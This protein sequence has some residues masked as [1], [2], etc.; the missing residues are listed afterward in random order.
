[1]Q[2]IAII[3]GGFNGIGLASA[4]A[5]AKNGAKIA[6]GARRGDDPE[7]IAYAKTKIGADIFTAKLDVADKASVED[8]VARVARDLGPANILVNSAGIST[9]Q[10]VEGHSEDAWLNVINI[11]LNGVFRMIRACL[12]AMKSQGFGRIVN[13]AS[14]A[15]HT[16]MSEYAA[17]CASK[18]GLLGLTR[19]VALEGAAHGI[20]A[21]SVSPTWVETEMLQATAQEMADKAG[22]SYEQQIAQI[23]ASNPQK[24]LVKPEELGALVAFCC[25]DAA[26]ALTME[27]I[28]VNAGAHW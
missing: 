27:D 2:R 4:I 10:L 14:T 13:I 6:L 11:N 15:A 23:A 28:C 26:A 12:P 22:I 18:S 9:H 19:A 3:T 20:C 8:F 21:V 25:S 1:M 17:Y 16:A 24:R 5:L 7:K